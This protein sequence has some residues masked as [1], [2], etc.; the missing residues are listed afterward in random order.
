MSD[1]S[2]RIL[3]TLLPAMGIAAFQRSAEG[4][5]TSIAPPPAWFARLA[6]DGTFPFLGH[7][8]EEAN[9]FWRRG[10]AGTR[11]WGPC[12]EVNDAGREFHYRVAA[13]SVPDGQFLIFQLDPGSDRLRD[14]LQTVR[15]KTLAAE[16]DPAIAALAAVQREVRRRGEEI[17]EL[18]RRFLG[19][20][21]TEAQFEVWKSVSAKNDALMDIVDRLT[22]PSIPR[23]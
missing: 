15:E 2:D 1:M 7:I 4:S 13:V 10:A 18:L 19:T 16:S 3:A 17:H 20:A 11:E 21:P 22:R 14:V 8:L 9:E 6:S 12:A 23:G 5:F